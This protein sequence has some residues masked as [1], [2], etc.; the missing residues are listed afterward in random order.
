M[1][2]IRRTIARKL[3][4][5]LAT[6]LLVAC[7]GGADR[8]KA[9]VRLVNASSGYAGLDLRVNNELRQGGV[10][11]GNSAAY[12]EADPGKAFTLHSAGS[13][14]SLVN[15]TPSVSARRYFSVLA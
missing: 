2:L 7:G 13:M 9:Q 8:T 10:T 15:F 5:T 6:T 14:T 4:L 11:A 3:A 1:N 12:V